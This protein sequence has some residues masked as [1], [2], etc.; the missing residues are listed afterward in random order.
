MWKAVLRDV[1]ISVW[2]AETTE[3]RRQPCGAKAGGTTGHGKGI[4]LQQYSR[5]L[6]VHE[7]THSLSTHSLSCMQ[8]QQY[9]VKNNNNNNIIITMTFSVSSDHCG[10]H[11]AKN[12]GSERI[13]SAR[14][15]QGERRASAG[16]A[17]EEPASAGRA[18]ERRASAK[19]TL[20][21]AQGRRGLPFPRR[22]FSSRGI[23]GYGSAIVRVIQSPED[24]TNSR[25]WKRKSRGRG[26]DQLPWGE[27]KIPGDVG[28]VPTP[29]GGKRKPRERHQLP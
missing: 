25:G 13:V 16:R 2:F 8:R 19:I 14:R 3:T 18:G 7:T 22:R 1:G 29:V 6:G 11:S 21:G 26:R 15:A 10:R 4:N 12:K 17:R 5:T 24:V 20:C 27:I 9:G 28:T 23:E